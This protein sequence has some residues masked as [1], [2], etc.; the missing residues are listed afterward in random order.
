MPRHRA[1]APRLALHCLLFLLFIGGALPSCFSESPSG[2]GDDG[3][4]GEPCA[5]RTL[6]CPC[7]DGAC[8]ADLSCEPSIALCIDPSCI[9]GTELCTCV[10]GSSCLQGLQCD[11]GLCRVPPPPGMDSSGGVATTSPGTTSPA[12]DG[13]T[14]LGDADVTTVSDTIEPVTTSVTLTGTDDG[15]PPACQDLPCAECYAC[16]TGERA[17]CETVWGVCMNAS[18]CTAVADC[19][20]VCPQ[21]TVGCTDECC[22]A[23]GDEMGNLQYQAL[24]SCLENACPQCDLDLSCPI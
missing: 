21:G 12:D 24:A 11:G 9:P 7:E 10:D 16:Q 23:R 2:G 22:F 1:V 4:T 17:E 14:L 6:G 19:A 18:G 15:E 8:D 20:W 5:P 3:T 13:E